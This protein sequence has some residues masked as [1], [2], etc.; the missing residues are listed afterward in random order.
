MFNIFEGTV[1]IN[2][3]AIF[4]KELSTYEANQIIITE[5]LT[6]QTSRFKS[7]HIHV[8]IGFQI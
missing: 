8:D 4:Q 6:K 1:T 7:I 3:I 5:L 2:R